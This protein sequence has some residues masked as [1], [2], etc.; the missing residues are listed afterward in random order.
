VDGQSGKAAEKG[1]SEQA[2]KHVKQRDEAEKWRRRFLASLC[3]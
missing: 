1:M 3:F 2:A